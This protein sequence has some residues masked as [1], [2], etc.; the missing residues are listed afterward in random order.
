M[1]WGSA[2]I[3]REFGMHEAAMVAGK[4]VNWANW[5]IGQLAYR[6]VIASI[7]NTSCQI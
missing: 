2:K 1:Q 6:H 4:K 3:Q 7:N 5:L